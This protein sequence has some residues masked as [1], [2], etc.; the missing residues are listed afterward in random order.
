MI[1]ILILTRDE[2]RNLPGCLASV[3]WS[4]DVVVFDSY[5]TDQTVAIAKS[6]GA[7][8]VQRKFDDYASQRN[9]ALDSVDYKYP[10]ILMVDADERL[11]PCLTEEMQQV[12]RNDSCDATLYRM[13]RKDFFQNQ[14]LK[15]SSGYPTW[16]SRLMKKGRVRIERP[17]NEQYHTD[18]KT[19]H[20]KGH[21]IHYPFNKGLAHW[22]QKHNLYSS[23]EAKN[24]AESNQS[25]LRLMQLFARDPVIRRKTLKQLAYRIPAR[26]FFAFC[27]LYLLRG[28]FLDGRAGLTFCRLRALYEYLIDLKKTELNFRKK[29]LPF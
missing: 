21:L 10:W 24:L 28:G 2:E 27:Y 18:G 8:V 4:D 12:V 1:S 9:A 15:H 14:W 6:A 22:L 11:S 23:M 7:R 3:N 19:E 13:R 17:V 26:P 20:L 29:S 25:P 5:S 16:F